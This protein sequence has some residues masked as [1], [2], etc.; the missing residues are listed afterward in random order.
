MGI[1]LVYFI[2]S[3]GLGWNLNSSFLNLKNSC[4]IEPKFIGPL[5]CFGSYI[6]GLRCP[7]VKLLKNDTFIGYKS[8]PCLVKRH[9]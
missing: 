7:E 9:N 1:S 6:Y 8:L 5:I 2:V 4:S 3:Y